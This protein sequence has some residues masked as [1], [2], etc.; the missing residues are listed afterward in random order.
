MTGNDGCTEALNS[1]AHKLTGSTVS[2][3]R[4]RIEA[5]PVNYALRASPLTACRV[6]YGIGAPLYLPSRPSGRFYKA[7]VS[8]RFSINSFHPFSPFFVL[9]TSRASGFW[10]APL[11][12]RPSPAGPRPHRKIRRSQSQEYYPAT[13][14]CYSLEVSAAFSRQLPSCRSPLSNDEG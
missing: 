1:K 13:T 14:G 6:W 8:R 4:P 2:V 12:P 11:P 3:H 9:A 10:R 7:V 5:V